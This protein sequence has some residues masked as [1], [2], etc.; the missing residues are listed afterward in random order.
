MNESYALFRLI[1]SS[2]RRV[3][4]SMISL[5][6]AGQIVVWGSAVLHPQW[7][8]S[9]FVP[10]TMIC[11]LLPAALFSFVVFD[12]GYQSDL[13]FT[14]SSCNHWLLR[15]P[16]KSWKIA[17][18]PVA[19]RTLWVSV[20]WTLVQQGEAWLQGRESWP[21]LAPCL[22]LA[23]AAIW[24]MGITWRPFANP[25]FRLLAL[26]I[27]AIAFYACI[28]FIF[29]GRSMVAAS[30][31]GSVGPA[32]L[33][34]A[35]VFYAGGVVASF[36]AVRLARTNARGMVPE[37]ER[38]HLASGRDLAV[39]DSQLAIAPRHFMR[40][41]TALLWHEWIRIRGSAYK[42]AVLFLFPALLLSVFVVPFS[43][44]AFVM[45]NV[46]IAYAG[47]FAASGNL[48]RS[49]I[50]NSSSLPTY[51]IASPI[52]SATLAWTR[53]FVPIAVAAIIYLSIAPAIAGWA[54][55]PSNRAHWIAWAESYRS[56]F[57]GQ[58]A[59]PLFGMRL[60]GSF[61]LAFAATFLSRVASYWWIGMTGRS[62]FILSASVVAIL[63]YL[64]PFS[65]FLAWFMKQTDW[66]TVQAMGP[67]IG[68][69][70]PTLLFVG[71]ATKLSAV[72][73]VAFLLSYRRLATPTA[74]VSV[75][76]SW[77]A[78]CGTLAALLS[79][80]VPDSRFSFAWM[81][82]A[83]TLTI[84]LARILAMPVAVAWNR[85]R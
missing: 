29:G 40:P 83:A 45:L 7:L 16:I 84:P 62:W 13:H 23:G 12:Y 19:L 85:H 68:H 14:A 61:C 78:A 66:S 73:I 18:I 5:V 56:W 20:L 60:A 4:I 44:P 46:L 49:T 37:T 64:L 2:H 59:S 48:S 75:I 82:A 79:L 27:V 8:Q 71:I 36:D 69:W 50:G 32:G 54:I 25:W 35:A 30:W 74:I 41:Y 80:L 24:V 63:F 15:M 9:N 42:T 38:R 43:G 10:M 52:R 22:C 65:L 31:R 70:L 57:D 58:D 21:W 17:A 72:A 34:M 77:A 55:W 51:L 33:A 39:N 3:L 81:L 53:A 26:L 11:S 47:I 67:W 6:A 1:L 28:A 76:A